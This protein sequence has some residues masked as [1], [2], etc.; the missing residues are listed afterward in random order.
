MQ[1]CVLVRD[2]SIFSMVSKE[3]NGQ[4]RAYISTLAWRK[5]MMNENFHHFVSLKQ[6]F[7]VGHYK[8]LSRWCL[9]IN[10]DSA[11]VVGTVYLTVAEGAGMA[12][13]R[14]KMCFVF[15]FYFLHSGLLFKRCTLLLPTKERLKF[16]FSK[17][18]QVRYR[19]YYTIKQI[20]YNVLILLL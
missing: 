18:S 8:D 1:L 6:T 16:I 3:V 13:T 4:V 11:V 14:K 19:Q 12:R 20:N 15:N 10:V 5:R 9:D 2:L 7:I 17:I